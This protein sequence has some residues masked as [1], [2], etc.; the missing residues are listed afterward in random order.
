MRTQA[1]RGQQLPRPQPGSPGPMGLPSRPPRSTLSLPGNFCAHQGWGEPQGPHVYQVRPSPPR[2]SPPGLGPPG[3]FGRGGPSSKGKCGFSHRA[4]GPSRAESPGPAPTSAVARLCGP[5]CVVPALELA[6]GSL[7]RWRAGAD[8]A[9][10]GGPHG[11]H[12]LALPAGAW[13]PGPTALWAPT[14]RP[15]F[16]PGPGDARAGRGHPCPQWVRHTALSWHP[17]RA[18][19]PP[20]FSHFS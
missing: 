19:P 7:A 11:G 20:E 8:H 10:A 18:R 15:S 2:P 6:P 12:T 13:A 16:A 14:C 17:L 4:R 5:G 1:V 3:R 9:Q